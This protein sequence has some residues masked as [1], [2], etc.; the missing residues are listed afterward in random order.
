MCAVLLGWFSV[1]VGVSRYRVIP[2]TVVRVGR[3]VVWGCSVFR[4]V[5]FVQQA[6]PIAMAPVCI[7]PKHINIAVHVGRHVRMTRAAALACVQS[8][9]KDKACVS[10]SVSILQAI[11]NIVVCVEE[12]VSV[13]KFVLE[14]A[15]RV[16]RS[17]FGAV[18]YVWTHKQM[19]NIV[20]R[21]GMSVR[22][23]RHVRREVV[24]E[25]FA[26]PLRAGEEVGEAKFV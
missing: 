12:H 24:S 16:R 25:L 11:P 1:V 4:G 5:V 17:L 15:V 19:S 21:V 14:G 8:V 9:L 2:C 10:T 18:D 6:K 26:P 13:G 3:L 7:F 20:V 23:G 22:V